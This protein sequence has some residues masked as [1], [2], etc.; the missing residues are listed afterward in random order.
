MNASNTHIGAAW[1]QSAFGFDLCAA[2]RVTSRIG[3]RRHTFSTPDER[4]EVYLDAMRPPATFVGHLQFHLRHELPHLEFLSRLFA[5]SGPQPIQDWV[6]EEPTGQ[7]AR[8]AAFLYEWLTGSQLIVPANLGGNYADAVDAEKIFCSSPDKI[9]KISRWRINDNLPGTRFFCPVLLKTEAVSMASSLDVR[10]LFKELSDEF[11]SDVLIR[12]AAWMTLRESKAS[13]TI[14]G[15]A[16]KATRIQRFADVIGRRT[17]MGDLPLDETSLAEIQG[18]ILG[19]V[20]SIDRL[21]LRSSPVFVGETIRHQEVVHYI[22]PPA[23]DLVNMLDGL[24]AF[25][26]KTQGQSPVMRSAVAA[27]AFVYIHPLADGNGRVHRFLIND[28]LRRDGALDAPLILPVSAVIGHP[29]NRQQYDSILDRVSKPIMN[30]FR[31]RVEFVSERTRYSDGVVSNFQFSGVHEARPAWRY[32]HLGDHVCYLSKVIYQTISEEMR[33][34]SRYLRS[35]YRARSAIKEIIEMPDA[36]ADRVIR[37]VI[38][39]EGNLSNVLAKEVP[40]FK[41]EET[42]SLVAAAVNSCFEKDLT[43]HVAPSPERPH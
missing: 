13:F 4:L 15:E 1:L 17:G 11:G 39:N 25:L 30:Q 21:G 23:D 9:S 26:V 31:G 20:K 16:D 7:Y 24:K 12:A 33:E 36:Q 40:Q 6:N 38:Q 43:E 22:A 8:R 19:S 41:S 3:S 34:E 5:A 18:E 27:F 2:L 14:E 29:A 10:A 42:W 35:H 28:I 32:L 37:S